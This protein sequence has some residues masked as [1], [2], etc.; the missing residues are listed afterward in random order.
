MLGKIKKY[1]DVKLDK[2]IYVCSNYIQIRH[3]TH[4]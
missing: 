4:Y 3:I 2:R 1:Y